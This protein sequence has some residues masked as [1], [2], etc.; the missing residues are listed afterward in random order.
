MYVS[1]HLTFL[2]GNDTSTWMNDV[3]KILNQWKNDWLS[4][5]F[6]FI[7]TL[8]GQY[9]WYWKIRLITIYDFQIIID[10]NFV[11][12]TQLEIYTIKIIHKWLMKLLK[13]AKENI[14]TDSIIKFCR[15]SLMRSSSIGK[16]WIWAV[17]CLFQLSYEKI[18]GHNWWRIYTD[19]L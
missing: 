14:F 3:L 18:R 11:I 12:L 4:L 8:K 7:E 6:E 2:I 17:L 1:G 5:F 15:N 13:N 19:S 9:I 16:T 10:I